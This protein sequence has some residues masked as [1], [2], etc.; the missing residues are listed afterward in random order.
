AEGRLRIVD[1]WEGERYAWAPRGWEQVVFHHDG[2]R[3]ADGRSMTLEL[4]ENVAGAVTFDGFGLRLHDPATGE[5]SFDYDSQGLVDAGVLPPG[6]E[7]KRDPWHANWMDWQDGPAGPEVYVSLCF[8]RQILAIGEPRGDLRWQLGAGLGWTVVD[9]DGAALGDEAL[10][11]CQ[12]GLEV[13]G[14]RLLVYDN[15]QDRDGSSVSEWRID[16]ATRTATRLWLWEE[17]GWQLDYLGDVD[18]LPGGR[19]LVT[20]A[21]TFG[22]A[23]I[24]EVDRAS[25]RVASRLSFDDRGYTYRAE[26]IDGCDLFT[27]VSACPSTRER[28]DRVAALLGRPVTG[29]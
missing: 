26:R 6:T 25:G 8:S 18:A 24:V 7:T 1:V 28:F 5:V 10:P 19:V 3:V 22:P 15:A 9:A 11:Q 2:K 13:E 17:P 27:S 23:Q 20:Q 16:P 29:R 21:T 12:H 14:D 4:R